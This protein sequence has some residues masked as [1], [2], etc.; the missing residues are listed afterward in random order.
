MGRERAKIASQIALP[1]EKERKKFLEEKG[2]EAKAQ[3]IVVHCSAGIG[4][5]GSVVLIQVIFFTH[6]HDDL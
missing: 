3:P 6:Y 5:T 2:N 1:K 4:R